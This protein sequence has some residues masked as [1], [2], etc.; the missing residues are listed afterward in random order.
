[1]D[2][3]VLELGIGSGRLALPLARRGIP[4][5]GIDASPQMI[6]V[7]RRHAANCASTPG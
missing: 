3:P 7:L 5:S 6:A 2:A 4:V 1:E